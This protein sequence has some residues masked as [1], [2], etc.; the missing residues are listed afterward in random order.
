MARW[1]YVAFPFL[2]IACATAAS[3]ETPAPTTTLRPR[4]LAS[5]T[6]SPALGRVIA[7]LETS[8]PTPT[9]L[10]H[11]IAEGDTLLS[12]AAEYG[13]DLA[14]ILVAN[15]GV[16]PR[17]LSVG[18]SLLIPRAGAQGPVATATPLPMTMSPVS[19]YDLIPSGTTC[20]LT[21]SVNSE[22]GVEGVVAVVTLVDGSG[23][24][25]VSEPAY[26][27][28]NLVVPGTPLAL[29]T[30]FEAPVPQFEQASAVVV[31]GL[32]AS[33]LETRYAEIVLSL[34]RTEI[35][36]DGSSAAV[37]GTLE[38][39]ADRKAGARLVVMA[40]DSEGQLVGLRIW[41][42]AEDELRSSFELVVRSLGPPIDRIEVSAEAPY[43]R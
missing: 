10:A 35:A 24:S 4:Q 25:L 9:P 5:A 13:V 23:R 12:V 43:I 2:L 30:T 8:G 33:D 7:P 3:Q 40:L 14:D 15:P 41:E 26:A 34:D 31:S 32:Q 36:Q 17:L 21:V 42:P 29:A 20:L 11:V 6:S 19:C 1:I 38:V 28:I 27:P 39:T 22:L 37:S 18:T 16:N